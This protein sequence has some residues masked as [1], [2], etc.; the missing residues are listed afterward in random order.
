MDAF[1][2]SATQDRHAEEHSRRSYTPFSADSSLA[3]NNIVIYDC[4]DDRVHFNSFYLP[5]VE[6]YNAR[7]KRKDRKKDLDY[8]S[9][10]EDGRE[11]Y[12][13]GEA[14]EKTFYHC[15]HS[16]LILHLHSGA[17][18]PGTVFRRPPPAQEKPHP[19]RV[20]TG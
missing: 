6:A 8:L 2:I 4:G 19:S 15:V 9:A 11:G 10:L 20:A 18:R 17:A 14:H 1:T 16:C 12:G 5:H 3:G 7:Q 13:K